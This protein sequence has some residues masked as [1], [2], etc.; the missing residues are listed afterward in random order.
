MDP[1]S[2]GEDPL[3]AGESPSLKCSVSHGDLP[4]TLT[5][6]FNGQPIADRADVSTANVGRRAS[7]L[8]IDSVS[9]AHAGSYTCRAANLAGEAE[10]TANL[11][12]NGLL[13]A[14]ASACCGFVSSWA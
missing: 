6:F 10:H 7:I 4:L 11:T 5:W 13:N 9:G 2:F 8:S 1:F 14:L 3:S 12:V